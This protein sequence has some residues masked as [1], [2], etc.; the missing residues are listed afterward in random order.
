MDV[1]QRWLAS[2]NQ[3]ADTLAK[4]ILQDRVQVLFAANARWS[5]QAEQ[6]SIHQAFLATQCLHDISTALFQIRNEL[7]NQPVQAAE[8]PRDM[9]ASA[10]DDPRFVHFPLEIPE[11]TGKKWDPGWL[12]LVCYYFSLLQWQQDPAPGPPI[13]L[14]DM[15]VDFFITFQ[16]T[17][18]VNKKN[19][20]KKHGHCSHISWD[21]IKYTNHLPS[22]EEALLLPPPLLTE[23][24]SMWMHTIQY[25]TPLVHLCPYA[26]VTRRSLA[27]VGYSNM[28][29]SWPSRPLLLSGNAESPFLTSL[30]KPGARK[31]KYRCIVPKATP[32]PLPPRIQ[33]MFN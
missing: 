2:G 9:D 25:L 18:P 16:V 26:Q 13:S 15:M 1:S 14:V 29:P 30:I 24:H 11:F 7:H 21:H 4:R 12:T 23:C 31:L 32:R 17:S 6:H 20:R 28:L 8:D 3:Q 19:L 5:S 27:H 33:E 22:K 10:S